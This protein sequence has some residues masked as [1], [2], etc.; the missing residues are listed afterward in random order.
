MKMKCPICQANNLQRDARDIP[1]VYK[2][3]HTVIKA[4]TGD[5]C[6]DC[7]EVILAGDDLL[8]FGE[9][10]S[11]FSKRVLNHRPDLVEEINA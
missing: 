9:E 7:G 1:H 6:A 5:F 4:I 3:E 10:M 8:R 11:V 2:N